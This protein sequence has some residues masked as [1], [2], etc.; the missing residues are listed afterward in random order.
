MNFPRVSVLMP[1]RNAGSF[2]R[3]A[4]SSVLQQPECLELLVADGGS[5][6]GSV[7]ELERWAAKDSRV[8]IVS[9]CDRGP[10]H[11]LNLAFKE[12]RGTIIGWLNADDLY[13]P[14]ALARA[15]F[16]LLENP[17]W[18][19]VYGEG[20]E[21][22][23][24][25]GMQRR[26]PTLPP[27]VGIE[28]FRDFCF[29]CQPSVVFRRTMGVMLGPFDEHWKTA[30]DFDYWLRAFDAFPGRIGYIPHLQGRTR[31]HEDT[32]TNKQRGRVALEAT[33][34]ISRYF[35]VASVTRLHNLGL[36]L[37]LGLA[38]AEPG[39]S[40]Q[41]YLCGLAEKARPWLDPQAF[42]VFCRDWDLRDDQ[43]YSVNDNYR[44]NG[45]T[46]T[47]QSL[48]LRLLQA[49]YPNLH[50][51]APGSP[52]Q[53]RVRLQEFISSHQ[54]EFPVLQGGKCQSFAISISE[55]SRLQ[56][57]R[58]FGVNLIGHAYEV[59]GIG[60]DIRMAARALQAVDVPCSVLHHPADNGASCTERTLESLIRDCPEGA[61]FAFNLIC[62]SAPMQARWLLKSGFDVINHFYTIAAWPW[63]T[64]Q[65]P[66]TYMPLFEVVDEVWSSSSFTSEALLGPANQLG[67]PINTFSMAAQI[68]D[69]DRFCSISS[70]QQTRHKLTLPEDA[71]IFFYSFDLNSTA[72]RKNPIA[73]LEAFQQAF[74][75]PH[76]LSA[77]GRISNKHHLSKKVVLLIKTFPPKRFSPELNWLQLRSNEDS[78]IHLIEANLD[79][80][81]LLAM[82]GCSDVFLSL[83]RSEGFGRGL[84]EAFQLGLDV[85]AT[86]YGGNTDFCVGPLAHPVRFKEVPI[87][88]DAYPSAD[89]H[90]WAEP[91]M[92]HAVQLMRNVAERRINV[93]L[94][95]QA[96][97]RDV[98]RD[99]SVLNAYRE[100][101]SYAVAGSRYKQR[102]QEIWR[103][104]CP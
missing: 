42:K 45:K 69:P 99:E 11:A 34:L 38:E 27:S 70:R 36:E 71:V 28:A 101:F 54:Q 57:K 68:S 80:D 10:A 60:E 22:N 23:I 9:R 64:R 75:L 82:Y 17:Q 26:Y 97:A 63:E 31:L 12:A 24:S 20:D 95:P 87:P 85:I 55:R 67:I 83:H 3:A 7:E 41:E 4:V 21:F 43:S 1:C 59:F 94:N 90:K 89:G 5:S 52:A 77:K 32:I 2:L 61:P 37:Q 39:Q 19:M 6:D 73:A 66:D 46:L 44:I 103:E 15:V 62:L 100:R 47:S 50:P 102:L 48:E 93:M 88:R 74:P 14:G 91:D 40:S 84:A 18:L 33:E 30:F 92:D 81:D 79:R 104:H 16:A 72:S 25:T 56:F 53:R 98:S 78:R 35:D 86:D 65:W 29:I 51:N 8:R 13:P 58:P 96:F 76:L 49:S